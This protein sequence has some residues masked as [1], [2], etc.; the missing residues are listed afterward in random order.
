MSE[1]NPSDLSLWDLNI[2][3][4]FNNFELENFREPK[5]CND[6][7]GVW[8]IKDNSSRYYKALMY[9][10]ALY[11]DN[12][13]KKGSKNSIIEILEKISNQNIGNP[14]TINYRG[15]EV[16]LDYILAIEELN[17]CDEVLKESETICEIGAGFGRTCHSILSTH[18]IKEYIIIDIPEVLNISNLFLKRVLKKEIFKKINFIEA[19][20]YSSI[21]KIDLVIN[22]DSL[23]EIP[24]KTS[25]DYFNW[26]SEKGKYFFSKNAMGKYDPNDIDI[27]ITK[28]NEYKAALKMGIMQKKYKLHNTDERIIAVEEY[29]KLY[30]PKNFNLIKSQRG[31]GQYLQHQLA[32]FKKI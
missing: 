27:E 12:K 7:L 6:L 21:K 23:Q 13:L 22:I 26:I 1:N 31:F 3:N 15:K 32:L 2:K 4:S 20:N 16:S 29:L 10:F 18:D 25:L 8:S 9:E 19:N 30:C 24:Y 5:K 14:T 11:M 17:F 28:V